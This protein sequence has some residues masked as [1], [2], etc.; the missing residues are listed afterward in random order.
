MWTGKLRKLSP[1]DP[2]PY[3]NSIKV[4][5]REATKKEEGMTAFLGRPKERA[6]KKSRKS[7]FK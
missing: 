7:I 2:D 3:P 4:F 1:S 5:D 6:P